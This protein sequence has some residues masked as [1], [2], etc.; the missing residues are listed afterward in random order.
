MEYLSKSEN[1]TFNIALN[2]AKKTKS[3]IVLSGELG[4][5]KTAFVKG[6]VS[7]Y[8]LE[9]EVSSPTYTIVNEYTNKDVSIFH[10]DLYRINDIQNYINTVGEEYLNLGICIFEW[11]NLI[12]DFLPKNT[13]YVDIQKIDENTRKIMVNNL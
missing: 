7:L 10:F 1:D 8:N 9:K 13:I 6:Y 3:H 12:K 5:G 4:S 2:I 11:G